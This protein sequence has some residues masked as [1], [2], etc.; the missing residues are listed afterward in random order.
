MDSSAAREITVQVAA[1]DETT[2]DD[3][4]TLFIGDEVT[5]FSLLFEKLL[6]NNDINF[7]I[8]MD[9]LVMNGIC[10][11]LPEVYKDLGYTFI[12]SDC[13]IS[14]IRTK[15]KLATNLIYLRS[16]GCDL[17]LEMFNYLRSL[18]FGGIMVKRSEHFLQIIKLLLPFC[19]DFF[20]DLSY[21]NK[22]RY[23]S[24][25]TKE[26]ITALNF[27]MT[28]Y[29][30]EKNYK[31][32]RAQLRATSP[33]SLKHLARNKVRENVWKNKKMNV[34]Y[35]TLCEQNLPVTLFKYLNFID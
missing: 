5:D 34:T 18:S 15:W 28:N 20:I 6:S 24:V 1:P 25:D 23:F 2:E 29:G 7:P 30:S 22:I 10:V 26:I 17:N 3:D 27:L 32:L 11:Q 13:D 14:D 8:I 35:Y 9:F 33:F 4:F 16:S 19:T 31:F 21:W 12:K